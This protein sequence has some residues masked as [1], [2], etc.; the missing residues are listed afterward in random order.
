VEL[1][2]H[3]VLRLLLLIGCLIFL[4]SLAETT[5]PPLCYTIHRYSLTLQSVTQ[6]ST[7]LEDLSAYQ[8][9]TVELETGPPNAFYLVVEHADPHSWM[10]QYFHSSQSGR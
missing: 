3:K 10:E 1:N 4:V 9:F 6:D 8:G 5:S 2:L 7:A